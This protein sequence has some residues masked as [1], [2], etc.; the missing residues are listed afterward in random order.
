MQTEVQSKDLKARA[1]HPHNVTAFEK[2]TVSKPPN[3]ERTIYTVLAFFLTDVDADVR[4]CLVL[5]KIRCG[6]YI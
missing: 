4:A 5:S 2:A 3:K 1:L 6:K